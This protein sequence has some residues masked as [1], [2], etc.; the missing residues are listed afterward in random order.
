MCPENDFLALEELQRENQLLQEVIFVEQNLRQQAQ[1]LLR[2]AGEKL[3]RLREAL[4]NG[5]TRAEL[6]AICYEREPKT[7]RES[8]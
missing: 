3:Q 5:A 6:E 2:E 4:E 1:D 8:L 7:V